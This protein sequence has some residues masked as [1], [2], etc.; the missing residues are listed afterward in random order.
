MV[1]IRYECDKHGIIHGSVSN[2]TRIILF[3]LSTDAIMHGRDKGLQVFEELI[4]ASIK[5]LEDH[6]ND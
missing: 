5:E 2:G 6:P 3:S 4:M 1:D